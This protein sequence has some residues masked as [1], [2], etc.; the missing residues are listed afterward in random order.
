MTWNLATKNYAIL[1]YKSWRII[2]FSFIYKHHIGEIQQKDTSIG[3]FFF[4][5]FLIKIIKMGQN[6]C[7]ISMQ[8]IIFTHAIKKTSTCFETL[9]NYLPA[10]K[11]IW[12][13]N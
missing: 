1:K 12:I 13:T 4:L 5:F 8:W 6:N 3:F 9:K 11:K 2:S 10:D 7:R